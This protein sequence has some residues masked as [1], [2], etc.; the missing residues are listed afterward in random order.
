MRECHV[1][2]TSFTAF[3]PSHV[4]HYLFKAHREGVTRIQRNELAREI[5]AGNQLQ[6]SKFSMSA[7]ESKNNR[8]DSHQQLIVSALIIETREMMVGTS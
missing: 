6:F 8:F 3:N 5:I 7:F 4:F 2:K 1:K